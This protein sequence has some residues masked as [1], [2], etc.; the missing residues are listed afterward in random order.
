LKLS[1]TQ[2]QLNIT[3]SHY[4]VKTQGWDIAVR[5]EIR[6]S[7]I[8]AWLSRLKWYDFFFFRFTI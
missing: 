4:L 8:I 2:K 6:S 5:T 7:C 1:F 3:K